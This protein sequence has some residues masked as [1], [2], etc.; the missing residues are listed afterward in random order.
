MKN[1]LFIIIICLLSA[2]T[3]DR[4]EVSSPDC[5][6]NLQFGLDK[7]GKPFY[8][9]KRNNID[10]LSKS[11]LGFKLKDSDFNKDFKLEHVDFHSHDSYW[12]PV[13]GEEDSI[14]ENYNE[15]KIYLSE[16]SGLHRKLNIIFR[17][18]DDGIG[19]RYEFPE[20]KDLKDFIIMDELTEF[21]LTDDHKA[22]SIPVENVNFYEA[23]YQP[24]PASRMGW[25]STPVT[26][27]TKD[28]LF[29]SIHEANLTDYAAMNLNQT[30]DSFKLKADLTPWSTGEKVFVSSTR[31]TPWR[32][33]IIADKPGDLLLSRLMLN[34]NDSC[35][36]EDT[37][38]I[39]PGKYIGIW[40]AYHMNK[41]TWHAGPKHGATT[42]NVMKYMDF[43]A[44]HNFQGVLAEG[45]NEDWATW[46]FSFTKAYEDFDLKKITD[47]GKKLG[48]NLIGHH[49]T[50]G[51]TLNYESQ[52]EDAFALYRSYGVHYVKTGYVGNL[53]D[54]KERH[55]SQYGVRHYRKVIE[56]AAKYK[57]AID[58]HEP[59]MPTG[60]QRTYPNLMT[61]EGVRGQEYDAWDDNGGNPPSHTVTIPFTR[62]LAGPMDFTPATFS[63]KNDVKPHTRVW[64]TLGKQLAEFVVLYSPL[65][66]ASDMIENYEQNLKY[67]SFISACPT[68]WSKTV[69]PEAKIGEYVTVA[70]RAKDSGNWYIGA[71]TGDSARLSRIPLD[72]LDKDTE[73]TAIIYHDGPRADYVSNPTDC[74]IDTVKITSKDVLELKLAKSGGAAIMIEKTKNKCNN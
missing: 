64:T 11:Y 54:G 71:I 66:M 46:N 26:F 36:I 62:G 37:S 24:K 18:F 22:W 10:I 53:L 63:F 33:V 44:K 6:I 55:S 13:W 28:S 38:W 43:A 51:K 12:T 32:T 16:K 4:T 49:E 68:D 42:E 58:N 41:N 31:V 29:I 74:V 56:T 20:Q 61:Q 39:K 3:N 52:M 21:A 8:S 25:V 23:L 2:C 9:V 50:G 73:Y 5:R 1:V 27:E 14:R 7:E 47:Y 57:I 72:F 67:L 15:M 59:I 40:W 69:V 35:K 30:G 45:W 65:Q 17:V 34:L 70:R 19:F 48:V 60:L